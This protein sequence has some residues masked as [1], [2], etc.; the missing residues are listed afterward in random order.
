MKMNYEPLVS[1]IIVNY[2]NADY[3]NECLS[4]IVNQKY[5]N[6]EVIV[7]D[8]RS[9]DKSLKILNEHM[10]KIKLIVNKKKTKFG[11]FNQINS[12][13]NG[14]DISAGEIIFFLDS[15]DY[16]SNKKIS[17]IVKYFK[18]NKK[19][20]LVFDL[21]IYL[22]KN[23][24]KKFFLKRKFLILSNWPR[25]SRQSCISL[26][27]DYAKEI[28]KLTNV[29]KYHK[30]WFDFR[31]AIY[32]FIKFKKINI[33]KSHLT[34]YRQNPN[35]AS[36]QFKFFSKV[37]WQRRLEAHEYYTFVCKKLNIKDTNTLDRI[38]TRVYNSLF[39]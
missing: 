5:K 7:V 20:Q 3:I 38:V 11:S 36:K 10:A 28:F 35:T 15:D 16:F 13:K 1:V 31:V 21:P 4:S 37:W 26:R 29:K 17:K 25:F 32:S 30:I 39:V 2:N 18:D 14:F 9:T 33:I 8:D 6:I 24:S 34:Y 12:Y 19:E 22:Y 23:Y 27:R